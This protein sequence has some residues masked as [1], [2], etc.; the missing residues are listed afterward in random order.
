MSGIDLNRAGTP[1]LEIVSEPEMR[2]SAEAVAYARALHTLVT[3]DRHLRRQHAG[4]QLPR[5][6]Q[7]L[8]APGRAGRIRHP[9]RDQEPQLVQIPA[10]GDRLRGALADR[11]AGRRRPHRAGHRAV[12]PRHRRDAHDAQQGRRARLPLLPRSR[13]VAGEARRRL[14]RA[15]ARH[16]AR[17]ARRDAGTLSKRIRRL[18]LR[19]RRADRLARAGRLLRSC[20]K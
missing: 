2:S 7:R 10:A 17:T 20:G 18:A 4:R 12:R 9:P 8:G 19:R 15:G 6:R 3:L 14:D 16:A 5:R 1:L 13:S 11:D